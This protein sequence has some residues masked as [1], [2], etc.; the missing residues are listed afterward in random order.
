[1]TMYDGLTGLPISEEEMFGLWKVKSEIKI[2]AH[3]ILNAKITDTDTENLRNIHGDFEEVE[4]FNLMSGLGNVEIL[5][6]NQDP[7]QM[8]GIELDNEFFE[9]W[10]KVVSILDRKLHDALKDEGDTPST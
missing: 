4:L 1:M 6:R 9:A 8:P 5:L 7:Q 10:Q 3:R 2:T